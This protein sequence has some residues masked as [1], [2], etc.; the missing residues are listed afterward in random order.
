MIDALCH[1]ELCDDPTRAAQQAARVG[2]AAMVSAGVDPRTDRAL[3]PVA[4]PSVWR[5]Y[6]I[7]PQAVRPEALEEQLA[8]LERRLQEPEVVALGECGLDTRPGLP[9][10]ADQERAFTAQL[11][12]AAR[13]QL[14]V[15]LHVVRAWPRALAL[16]EESG[17]RAGVWHGFVGPKEAIAPAVRL[18][19]YLSVGGAVMRTH[20]RRPREAV[21]HIPGERLLVET[22]APDLP[23]ERL[24]AVVEEVGLLR[25]QPPAAVAQLCADNARALY[26]PSAPR[27]RC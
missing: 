11:E 3:P 20:A 27:R 26:R 23:P 4:A 2:V 12:V 9:P 18:G 19:L 14:P 16:L 21:P 5:A 1:L 17:V 7:H 10:L 25:G 15:V 24:V 8:A 22:D 13:R 6:G